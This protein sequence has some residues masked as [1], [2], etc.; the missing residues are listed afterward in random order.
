M[1]EHL[2]YRAWGPLTSREHTHLLKKKK[3]PN[4]RQRAVS[5]RLQLTVMRGQQGVQARGAWTQHSSVLHGREA[6]GTL[7][8]APSWGGVW[9][10]CV[11]STLLPTRGYGKGGRGGSLVAPLHKYHYSSD[12]LLENEFHKKKRAGK[13]PTWG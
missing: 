2:G 4:S 12:A 11:H 1:A 6:N 3:P 10:T 13:I 7:R 9:M 8:G 5:R